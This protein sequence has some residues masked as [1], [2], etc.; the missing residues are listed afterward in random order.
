[1]STNRYAFYAGL[2]VLMFT[3]MAQAHPLAF[4]AD[5]GF[6]AGL[7]HPFW[8]IDHLLAMI[9][10]GIWAGRLRGKVVWLVPVTFI[11]VMCM[12]SGLTA[13]GFALPMVESGIISSILVLGLIIAGL[14]RVPIYSVLGIVALFAVFHG[15]A[16]GLALPHAASPASYGLGFVLAT[17][18]LNLL[19]LGLAKSSIRYQWFHRALGFSLIGAS[20]LLLAS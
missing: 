18:L 6:L 8:G 5:S 1:M 19:G 15:Y 20:A 12:A 9:A 14:I 13:L 2:M 16:H 7:A 10:V 17:A 3:P 4:V 11:S